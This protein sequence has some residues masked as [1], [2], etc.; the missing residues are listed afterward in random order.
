ML[1]FKQLLIFLKCAVPLGLNEAD[2]IRLSSV[3]I[4]LDEEQSSYAHKWRNGI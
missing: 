2:T 4:Y 3:L 1:V